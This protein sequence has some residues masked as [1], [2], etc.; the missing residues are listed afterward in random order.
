MLYGKWRPKGFDEV[1][2]QEHVVTTLRNALATG[3]VAHAYLFSGPRGTGKTTTARI[4]ARAINCTQSRE[5]DPCGVCAS[6]VEIERGS[7]LDLI[8]M[9][10]ASNRG[11]DDIRQLREKIAFAPGGGG[12]K[13]YLLDEVHMLTDQAWNALLKTLEEP[14]PHAYFILA[15]TELHEVLPTVISRCQRFDFHRVAGDAI[16]SRLSYI[17]AQEGFVV[18]EEGLA[19]IAKQSKGGLRDAITL[20]EQVVARFGPAPTDSDVFEA[21]GLIHDHRSVALADTI[22]AGDLAVALDLVKDVADSGID[23]KA[24]TMQVIEELRERLATAAREGGDVRTLVRAI[25]ELAGA[26]FR[27]DPANPVPLEVACAAAI[28]E[29]MQAI[30]AA[31]A[32]PQEHAPPARQTRRPA[33]SSERSAD[34]GGSD[35]QRF[36]RD[37]YNRCSMVNITQAAFLNGSCEV[38]AIEPDVLR[39]G[40]YWP[41]HMQKVDRDCRALIEEQASV[42]L[43]RQVRLAVELIEKQPQAKAAARTGHLAAAARALGATPVRKDPE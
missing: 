31:P 27:L 3:Q 6:C 19:A 28:L 17:C 29:P 18:G 26:D 4:L 33:A 2:G 25:S 37:L 15:T 11:I 14:P 1:A 42:L 36:L 32:A 10:A 30:A 39:L 12:K 7:A 16:V 40:F 8:E 24:F 23:L 13:V 20:L 21:L 9:D 41:M 5:G 43:G 38:I 34:S 35:E 22:L